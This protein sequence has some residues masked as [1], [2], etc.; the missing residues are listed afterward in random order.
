MKPK[1]LIVDDDRNFIKL[2]LSMPE[3]RAY[4]FIPAYSPKDALEI[5]DRDD[6]SLAISDVVFEPD[7]DAGIVL[8]ATIRNNFPDV[9]VILLTAYG[10]VEKAV[11]AIREGA[12]HY[13]KKPLTEDSA[14]LL[15]TAVR[16]ALKLN[17]A[18][19]DA[20]KYRLDAEF[21][22][23]LKY[24]P[25]VGNSESIRA[26][27]HTISKVAAMDMDV[28]I[29][30]ETGT[31]KELAAH[32]V[33]ALSARKEKV[34]YCLNCSCSEPSDTMHSEL[35]GHE[36][37]SFT[38]AIAK[39]V[40]AFEAVNGGTL[41]LDEI[42]EASPELQKKLLRV[43]EYKEFKSIGGTYDRMTDFRLVAATN[44][45]LEEEI[46]KGRFREDLFYRLKVARIHIAPLRERKEDIPSIATFFLD[47]FKSRY[48][49]DIKG[50]SD[51]ALLAMASY[52]WPGNVRELR[53]AVK[54]A[55]LYCEGDTIRADHLFSGKCRH[56]FPPSFNLQEIEKFHVKL[57]LERCGHVKKEAA[58][59]LGISRKT[60]HE[61]IKRYGLEKDE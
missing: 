54:G 34:F 60:L 42:A 59:L 49:R 28:L 6:V 13:F 57:A 21:H 1:I 58:E 7:Q 10:T 33:H 3:A 27:R 31:G 45:F 17:R 39:R 61:K 22:K 26:V 48:H 56:E 44:K 24:P 46:N 12:Y 35:F 19:K 51:E 38:G 8:S 47:R 11:N 23:G 9:P 41:F 29:T 14:D 43:L 40:G 32:E 52:D 53:H 18:Q 4:Q 37:G 55:F 25:I 2:F 20:K 30:G 36:K 15:W 50:F 5:L 16:E